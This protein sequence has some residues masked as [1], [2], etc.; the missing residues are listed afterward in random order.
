MAYNKTFQL[1]QILL[2]PYEELMCK[3][4]AVCNPNSQNFFIYR[5][6]NFKKIEIVCDL[7]EI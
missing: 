3:M 4:S 7:N 6:H 5:L 1:P 2:Q